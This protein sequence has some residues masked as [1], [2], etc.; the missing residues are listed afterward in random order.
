MLAAIPLP[1]SQEASGWWKTNYG[2]WPLVKSSGTLSPEARNTVKL[3]SPLGDV[4]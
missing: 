2:Y 3:R 1:L 4:A